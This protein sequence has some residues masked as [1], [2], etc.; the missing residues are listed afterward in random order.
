MTLL[1]DLLHVIISNSFL[2]VPLQFDYMRTGALRW[3]WLPVVII[4]V[5]KNTEAV[6]RKMLPL[7][8]KWQ[9]LAQRKS[10]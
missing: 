7:G 10:V 2:T 6:S 4:T 3:V 5:R 9:S 1:R 8:G